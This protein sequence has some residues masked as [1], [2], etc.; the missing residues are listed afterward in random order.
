MG[1]VQRDVLRVF[2]GSPGDLQTEREKAREVVERLNRHLARN[3]GVHV[4]L[5]GWEDTLP[6][7][8][9]PQ[10]LINEDVKESDLFIGLM[11]QRW[12]S[13]TSQSDGYSSGFE[14][15]FELARE[16]LEAGQLEDIWLSFKEIDEERRRDPDKQLRQ[17][18]LFRHKITEGKSIFYKE[19]PSP[20][21]WGEL[22]YDSLVEYLTRESGPN[23]RPDS[24]IPREDGDSAIAVRG[25]GLVESINAVS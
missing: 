8:S 4:E 7:S 21:R 14:E 12:G 24:S 25:F 2:I 15:E 5:R 19:F 18:L 17:V 11:W 13:P 20:E 1:R 16:Q 22:L 10:Q 6:G 9:R 3:L 23:S